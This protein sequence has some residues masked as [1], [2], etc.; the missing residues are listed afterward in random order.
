MEKEVSLAYKIAIDLILTAVVLGIVVAFTIVSHDVYNLKLRQDTTTINIRN[1]AELYEYNDKIV[2]GSDIV[3][4]ILLYARVYD[5]K[6]DTD[7]ET[8]YFD[9]TAE[10]EINSQTGLIYGLDLW[11]KETINRKLGTFIN[12]SFKSEIELDDTGTYVVGI[13]FTKE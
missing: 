10:S 13:T 3:D 8:I 1:Y 4:I 7:T 5:F 12:D 9:S 6:I 2:S 11:S